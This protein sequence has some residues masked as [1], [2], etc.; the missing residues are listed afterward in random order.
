[1]LEYLGLCAHILSISASIVTTLLQQ[2]TLLQDFFPVNFV[3]SSSSI[4]SPSIY[5]F[6]QICVKLTEREGNHDY[7]SLK[8]F[9]TRN[10]NLSLHGESTESYPLDH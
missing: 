6:P 1:M 5:V 9:P 3:L 4:L 10:L 8:K 2:P 7:G